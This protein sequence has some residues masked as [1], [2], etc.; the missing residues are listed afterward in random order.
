MITQ[1]I[2]I[3]NGMDELL[4]KFVNGGNLTGLFLPSRYASDFKA[5]AIEAKCIIDEYFGV[6]NDYSANLVST[7]NSGS[8]GFVGGPSYASVEETS[9]LIRAAVRGIERR[10][11]QTAA[12]GKET[13][14]YVDPARISALKAATTPPWDFVRVAE[15]CREINVAAANQ[16]NFS[17]AMLL[18]A[19]LDHI[20]PVL[21][22]STFAEVANN[23]GG[24]NNQRSFKKSM[25]NLQ[26]SLRNIADMHLH[27][28]I[29]RRE[30]VPTFVQ[31]DF[32]ADLDVLLGEVIRVAALE[33]ARVSPV[34]Q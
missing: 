2:D 6:P 9:K 24:P 25:Q 29:R 30:D 19:I 10:R 34:R 22:L 32:A 27:S 28:P 8:G 16:C 18:R 23:Y 14:P 15:L 3:A 26:G 13:K 21:G 5:M 33:A 17:I 4:P 7:V 1:L 11:T 12:P 20:P 31:V